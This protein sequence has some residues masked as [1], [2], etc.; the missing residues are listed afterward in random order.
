MFKAQVIRI[1]IFKKNLSVLQGSHCKNSLLN[2][3]M[4]SWNAKMAV[5]DTALHMFGARCIF[6]FTLCVSMLILF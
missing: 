6:S 1:H 5:K 3:D 2:P 4:I